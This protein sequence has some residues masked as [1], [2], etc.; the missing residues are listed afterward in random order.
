M[1]S[2]SGIMA[3]AD[4]GG[5]AID[6]DWTRRDW[7]LVEHG[8]D[9][10][11]PAVLLLAGGWCTAAFFDDLAAQPALDSVR[12]IA[13][14]APGHGMSR[15]PEDLSVEHYARLTGDLAAELGC[16][17]IGGHSFGANVA[18]ETVASGAFAGPVLLL[19]PALS[20]ADESR[21]PRVLDVLG[22]VFG[23]LPF[24]VALRTIGVGMR[25]TLPPE[26]VAPLVA[27]MKTNDPRFLRAYM[28]AYLAYLDRQG[29]VAARLCDAGVRTVLASGEHDDVGMTEE[30]RHV[31]ETC[32]H[33]SVVEIRDA[34]HFTLIEK[35]G[36]IADALLGLLY[37]SK[38]AM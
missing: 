36:R 17:V 13:A 22:R 37:G 16:D 7:D 23:H 8:A 14:T 25:Q 26:R 29:S 35:P 32:P 34:G 10:S 30:E 15:A 12:L 21:F 9:D 24:S 6:A 11:G 3:T 31:L 5:G 19:S 4:H 28:R 27:Q 18:L 38:T 20:R 1:F 2:Q 33:V